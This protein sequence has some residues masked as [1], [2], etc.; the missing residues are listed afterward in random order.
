VIVGPLPRKLLVFVRFYHG[1]IKLRLKAEIIAA[2][3]LRK[4]GA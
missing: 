3:T 1:A 2:T 4:R